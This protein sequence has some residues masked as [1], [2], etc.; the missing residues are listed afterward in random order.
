MRIC[1]RVPLM[2]SSGGICSSK[3]AGSRRVLWACRRLLRL[4]A[5]RWPSEE[6][7]SDSHRDPGITSMARSTSF[8]ITDL[9]AALG[10]GCDSPADNRFAPKLKYKRV[11]GHSCAKYKAPA[12]Q[13][14]VICRGQE[15]DAAALFRKS[16]EAHIAVRPC[17]GSVHADWP[18][19]A[20]RSRSRWQA[21]RR[22]RGSP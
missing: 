16:C 14:S 1:P 15:E 10:D 5:Q 7:G 9:A 20:G 17:A 12:I 18:K 13:P 21:E 2:S 22:D 3:A 6:N 19:N 8:P 11:C 4:W